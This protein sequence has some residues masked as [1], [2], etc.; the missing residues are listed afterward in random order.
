MVLN[1][2]SRC[3]GARG[4]TRTEEN[5]TF[6]IS[7]LKRDPGAVL[8]AMDGTAMPKI[9][10]CICYGVGPR[11]VSAVLAFSSQEIVFS[12]PSGSLSPANSC[13]KLH[14]ALAVCIGAIRFAPLL[15]AWLL[16]Q[17]RG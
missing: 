8:K 3:D 11:Y 14:S 5:G 2:P 15:D 12:S 7:G 17:A 13:A 16:T 9:S 6:L 1:I 4:C 10:L